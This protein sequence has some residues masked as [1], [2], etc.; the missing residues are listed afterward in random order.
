MTYVDKT[1][2]VL[3]PFKIVAFWEARVLCKYWHALCTTQRSGQ[4][5]QEP[6]SW[7]TKTPVCRDETRSIKDFKGMRS[8]PVKNGLFSKQLW[9]G[10]S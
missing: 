10:S 7:D 5:P 2:I 6:Q 3:F 8:N 4:S 1:E 9:P